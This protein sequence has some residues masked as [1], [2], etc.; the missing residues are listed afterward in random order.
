VNN[1]A[2][3]KAWLNRRGM[4]IDL[5]VSDCDVGRLWISNEM[6]KPVG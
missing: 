3:A 6:P 4:S 5:D 2:I 1:L